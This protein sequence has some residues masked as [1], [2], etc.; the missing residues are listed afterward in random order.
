MISTKSRTG[1]EPDRCSCCRMV[2]LREL[3]PHTSERSFNSHDGVWALIYSTYM[4]EVL[5]AARLLLAQDTLRSNRSKQSLT[6][7]HCSIRSG[8]RPTVSC[9]LFQFYCAFQM[10]DKGAAVGIGSA[11][12][13]TS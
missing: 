10:R 6:K 13:T 1:I 9:S 5:P 12:H 8:L 7:M 11:Q 4:Q 3:V 2:Q